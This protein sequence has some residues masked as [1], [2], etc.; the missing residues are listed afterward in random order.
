MQLALKLS[1]LTNAG[2]SPALVSRA[3]SRPQLLENCAGWNEA[4]CSCDAHKRDPSR[5]HF[6]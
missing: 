6:V 4:G 3:G 5:L 2:A 1:F